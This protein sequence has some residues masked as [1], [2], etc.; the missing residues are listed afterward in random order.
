MSRRL[1]EAIR[2]LEKKVK[3][4]I[5]ITGNPATANT[6]VTFTAGESI[7]ERDVVY[8]SLAGGEE[9]AGRVY[10][11]D[12]DS[13][14]KSADAWIVGFATAAATAGNEVEIQTYG[15]LD[16]FSSLV[17]GSVYYVSSTAG[18]I[19]LDN[20][21]TG[22]STHD[23]WNRRA[24]GVAV[25][26]TSLLIDTVSRS[27]IEKA[28]SGMGR[29]IIFGGISS[30]T[31]RRRIIQ[32][33]TIAV[34]H[35]TLDFGNMGVATQ[36]VSATGNNTRAIASGGYNGSYTSDMEYVTIATE[37]DAADFGNLGAGRAGAAGH[38][39]GTRGFAFGGRYSTSTYLNSIDYFAFAIVGIQATDFGDLVGNNAYGNGAGSPT[40]AIIFGGTDDGSTTYDVIQYVTMGTTGNAVDFGDMTFSGWGRAAMSSNTRAIAAGGFDGGV[41][42]IMDYVTIA[43][44]GDATDFGDLTLARSS[45]AG[46]SSHVRGVIIGGWPGASP[47]H[48]DTMD[49]ITI[50]TVGNATDFA[51]VGNFPRY[52][53]DSGTSDVHGGLT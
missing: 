3:N 30:G 20:S 46:V 40:R 13:I 21:S 28:A 7:S 10:Q 8:V 6:N 26:S 2:R 31:T 24:V 53:D 42:N 49:Y 44:T 19:T 47:H 39:T 27:A 11:A 9:T 41:T 16:G 34:L 14:S 48:T 37:A 5:S 43:T 23:S 33:I 51:D 1:E 45:P 36:N 18:G 15:T 35:H 17:A 12:Y 52:H 22:G 25:S 50:A 32:S 4:L 38:S 29:A